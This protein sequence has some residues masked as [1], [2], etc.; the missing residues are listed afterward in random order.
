MMREWTDR[1]PDREAAAVWTRQRE[2][3]LFR[4][5]RRIESELAE[6]V[7][8]GGG[9]LPGGVYDAMRSF[10]RLR[11]RMFPS[12]PA[13]PAWKILITLATTPEDS[14]KSTITGIRYGADVPMTTVLRYLAIMEADGVVERVTSDTDKRMVRIRL[15]AEGRRRLDALAQTWSLR[16]LVALIAPVALLGWLQLG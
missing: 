7:R 5:A 11:E 4:R 1:L 14:D 13:D 10:I 12:L 9:A 2:Q 3:Q 15:T 8:D 16:A 6:T